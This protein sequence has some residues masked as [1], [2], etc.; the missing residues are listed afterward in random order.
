MDTTLRNGTMLLG[1]RYKILGVLGQGGFGI[2]YLAEDTM[3]DSK[4]AIKEFYLAEYCERDEHTCQVS[5]PVTANRNTVD[6][7]RKKFIREART[8]FKLNHPGIVRVYNVFEENGTAYYVM[9]HIDGG[10]L[11]DVVKRRGAIPEAEALGYIKEA[12]DALAYIHS[13]KVN[14]LDIK[15]ANLMVR[16]EDHKVLVID[17]GISKQ[18]DVEEAGGKTTTHVCIS[19]GYSPQ[20]QY[21]LKGIQEFSPQSDVYSL[22]ATLF[23]LLTG[24]TPPEASEI[25]DE[26]LPKGK[27]VERG[28]SPAVV[29]A[30]EAA[31]LTKSRRT[32]SVEAFMAG[33]ENTNTVHDG[34]ETIVEKPRENNGEATVKVV[35]PP[36]PPKFPELEAKRSFTV[37]GVS[38]AMIGVLGGTFTM[39]ATPEQK[40][41]DSDEKPVHQV[42]LNDYYI[43]ETQVT[44]ELW[45]AVMGS[46]P[47]Y[48]KG[49]N[50]PV[51]TVSWNDCQEFIKKLNALTG[52]RFRLPS[53]AEWEFSARGGT[54]SRGYQYSGSDNI[55][56]VAWYWEN[57][58]EFKW[59]GFKDTR[60]THPVAK[61][62]PN[63]LGIYDMSGNVWEWCQDRYGKY[64]TEAQTN[65]IGPASGHSRVNRGGGWYG[66]AERCRTASRAGDEPSSRYC[67]L[68]LRLVLSL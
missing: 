14:H 21:S 26:G 61:K 33:I 49:D 60:S 37:N 2:T 18:Y 35:S 23:K 66:N 24:E 40:D 31:M 44:Q 42:T 8:I 67:N 52:L 47:S 46:N 62:K 64:S 32:Q 51:E 38:F 10:S 4:V 22:A 43:G 39:G 27:L 48:F 68:G 7:A 45:K 63:E 54:K 16:R 3:L 36:V 20:E 15:P 11:G 5:V 29:N 1:D 28:V 30:I 19:S 58:G 65:P 9:E 6:H 41:P 57:S 13:K 12:A 56:E 55:D 17:F 50:L 59:L 25:I 53:E 34:E